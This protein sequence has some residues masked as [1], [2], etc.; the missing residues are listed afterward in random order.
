MIGQEN[1]LQLIDTLKSN[2]FP[3]FI[4]LEGEKGSGRKT[5]AREI[6][7]RLNARPVLSEISTEEIRNVINL[8]Y[9]VSTPTVYILPDADKMHKAAKNA[10]LKVTE[11]PPEK[12]YF[13][14]TT[15]NLMYMLST[16]I[17]RGTVL[18]MDKYSRTNKLDYIKLNY[19]LESFGSNVDFL[20]DVCDTFP[21]IDAVIDYNVEEFKAFCATTA[22]FIVKAPLANALKI[23]KKL[24]LKEEDTGYDPTLFMKAVA[25]NFSQQLIT[26][27]NRCVIDSLT[28]NIRI[29]LNYINEL[30]IKGIHKLATLD[31]WILEMRGL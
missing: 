13:I 14:L 9:K 4:I 3:R 1:L 12:S 6:A 19:S 8:S 27:E 16:L 2:K 25:Y 29:T 15:N 23:P 18:K 21:E 5:M 30:G 26:A 24:K 20:C 22:G 7:K 31:A 17:S 10:L 11:E 28:E